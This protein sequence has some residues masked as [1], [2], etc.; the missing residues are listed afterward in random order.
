MRIVG[1][2]KLIWRNLLAAIGAVVTLA[3]LAAVVFS[4]GVEGWVR[5]NPILL[6]YVLLLVVLGA[7]VAI[8]Y[9][10]YMKR[11]A[12][13]DHDR[14]AVA[15]VFS[16]LPPDGEI[17]YC[18]RYEPIDNIFKWEHLDAID[19]VQRGI[20]ANIVGLDNRKANTAYRELEASISSFRSIISI[21]S[22][23]SPTI[24]GVSLAG[25]VDYKE[26]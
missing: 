4:S 10:L 3:A 6:Y 20:V 14:E 13:S 24:M 22:Q 25:I 18:L 12:P 8:N 17:I 5:S 21:N 15:R 2:L 1:L 7:F 19:E 9:L 16:G 23:P 11:R 26:K